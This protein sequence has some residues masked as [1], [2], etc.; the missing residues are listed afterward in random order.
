MQILTLPLTDVPRK[1]SANEKLPHLS[2]FNAWIFLSL[3]LCLW[4]LIFQVA[5]QV[6]I[7]PSLEE[8]GKVNCKG[9]SEAVKI[10]PLWRFLPLQ[11]ASRSAT[12]SFHHIH[13]PSCGKIR[14]IRALGYSACFEWTK[15]RAGSDDVVVMYCFLQEKVTNVWS[16]LA[17]SWR[18]LSSW[19]VQRM[20]LEIH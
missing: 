8:K 5:W 14:K 11:K 9:L 16:P 19:F 12:D 18:A 20:Q 4:Y 2:L 10:I 6:P 13:W 7:S 3:T 17:M 15:Y 1:A